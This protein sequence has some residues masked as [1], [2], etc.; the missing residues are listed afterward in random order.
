MKL[1]SEKSSKKLREEIQG[2]LTELCDGEGRTSA[3]SLVDK[4]IRNLKHDLKSI[5]VRAVELDSENPRKYLQ[6]DIKTARNA[7]EVLDYLQKE[8]KTE[9][10][11]RTGRTAPTKVSRIYVSYLVNLAEFVDNL[12]ALTNYLSDGVNRCLRRKPNVKFYNRRKQTDGKQTN[13]KKL[14]NDSVTLSGS[15]LNACVDSA[16]SVIMSP[17]NDAVLNGSALDTVRSALFRS[18][19]PHSEWVTDE[20]KAACESALEKLV[21]TVRKSKGTIGAYKDVDALH[22]ALVR[23]ADEILAPAFGKVQRNSK[24]AARTAAQVVYHESLFSNIDELVES[25]QITGDDFKGGV[26][27]YRFKAVLDERTSVMCRT[28]NG[29]TI[30]ASDKEALRRFT[31]PLHYNCRSHL[32]PNL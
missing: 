27:S 1:W 11:R 30:R 21:E 22:N 25:E 3:Q 29:M 15:R 20:I 12:N 4:Q 28:C 18:F 24:M 14:R 13:W 32:V 2:G 31:P 6:L 10:T 23:Q 26:V 5:L 8:N 16:K 17:A 9:R 7:I 19:G